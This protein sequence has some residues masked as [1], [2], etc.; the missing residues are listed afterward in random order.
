MLGAGDEFGPGDQAEGPV[1]VVPVPELASSGLG[2]QVGAGVF[3]EFEGAVGFVG[4]GAAGCVHAEG[5]EGEEDGEEG[6]ADEGAK[7]HFWTGKM[8]V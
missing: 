5:G 2:V 3:G 8:R 6:S 4:Y 1:P 7:M